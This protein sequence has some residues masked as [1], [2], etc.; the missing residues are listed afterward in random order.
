MSPFE[1]C[2]LREA[3]QFSVSALFRQR[4]NPPA[5]AG[6]LR[7]SSP[8]LFLMVSTRSSLCQHCSWV[9]ISNFPPCHPPKYLQASASSLP[10]HRALLVFL[11]IPDSPALSQD[12]GFGV[13]RWDGQRQWGG[14]GA[15][16]VLTSSP[17]ARPVQ[18]RTYSPI[19]Q[20]Q[21][22]AGKKGRTA[23]FPRV[24]PGTP[25]KPREQQRAQLLP[26]STDP[27]PSRESPPRSGHRQSQAPSPSYQKGCVRRQ[28]LEVVSA[29][30][31]PPKATRRS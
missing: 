18:M 19:L 10:K 26:S 15:E 8:S 29:E 2:V 31:A 14:E 25:K 22:F 27:S 28:L 11:Q 16:G 24:D 3:A 20:L 9:D 13:N 5:S 23:A 7:I 30:L 21:T 12:R 17:L 4:L 6:N 1:F